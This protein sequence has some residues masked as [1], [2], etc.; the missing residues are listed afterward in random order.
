MLWKTYRGDGTLMNIPLE[1]NVI[2]STISAPSFNCKNYLS[3]NWQFHFSRKIKEDLWLT[4]E[5]GLE[6]RIESNI[7][8][9]YGATESIHPDDDY[10]GLI[11][12]TREI[13]PDVNM[14]VKT[15]LGWF[16]VPA[17]YYGFRHCLNYALEYFPSISKDIVKDKLSHR[18]QNAFSPSPDKIKLTKYWKSAQNEILAAFYENLCKAVIESEKLNNNQRTRLIKKAEPLKK[19][20]KL[21]AHHF[22]YR[23]TPISPRQVWGRVPDNVT[24]IKLD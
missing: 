21:I 17:D 11:G 4:P 3:G 22:D 16:S 19:E 14:I 2:D 1:S 5:A 7:T 12:D 15:C 23:K 24:V 18:P 6:E 13:L 20:H 8:H 9:S 10:S